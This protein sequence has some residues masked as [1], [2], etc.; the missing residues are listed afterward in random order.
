MNAAVVYLRRR[1]VVRAFHSYREWVGR[2]VGWWTIVY[3]IGWIVVFVVAGLE[4]L[5]PL[6][7]PVGSPRTVLM[8]GLVLFF[9][10]LALTGRVPPVILD[11]RD[12]YRLGVAPVE[13]WSALRWRFTVRAVGAAAFGAFVGLVWTAVAP[14]LF[15]VSAPWA[16]PVLAM[17]FVARFAGSWLRYARSA[18]GAGYLG[19][20]VALIGAALAVMP[21]GLADAFVSPSP[22]VL[23]APALLAVFSLVWARKSLAEYWPP[24]FAPQSLV[25]TQLQ[26]MR[27]MQLM[28]G[29]AGFVKQAAADGGEK[30]RLLAALHDTPG[31]TRPRR[32]LPL[33]AANSPQW[34]AIAWRTATDLWRRPPLRMAFAFLITLSAV[35]AAVLVNGGSDALQAGA[36]DAAAG[37]SLL[38]GAGLLGGALGVLMSALLIARAGSA[39]LGPEFAVGVLPVEATERT[40]GRVTPGG[41]LFLVL[42]LPAVF[43]FGVGLGG[44]FGAASLV[45]LVLLAL[46]KYASWSGS[47]VSRWE[48][49]V[50]AA[51]FAALPSLILSAFG[52][53]GWTLGVQVGMLMVLLLISV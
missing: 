46:E 13:P 4:A 39:L 9:A 34:R 18:E 45:L 6:A 48:A 31:A 11:R 53:P 42:S 7:V 10:S 21:Y 40:L 43:Y 2:A 47:G 44:L 22:L 3:L 25:L 16:A 36:G 33:V 8:A 37:G 32:S 15:G 41:L 19:W 17:V 5:T 52:V 12:L 35:T 27:T 26:A 24:R 49:Q 23:A 30:R 1:T 28:A 51:I 14:S 38:G 50:V 20:A 29:M